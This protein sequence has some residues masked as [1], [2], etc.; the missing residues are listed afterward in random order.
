MNNEVVTISDA[1][2]M[3]PFSRKTLYKHIKQGKVSI[4][5]L[6]NGGRGIAISELV[7]V[8]GDKLKP[9][10]EVKESDK[11]LKVVTSGYDT[12]KMDLLLKKIESLENEV[13]R[14]NN[15]VENLNNRLEYKPDGNN[16]TAS[17][18]VVEKAEYSSLIDKMK[19]NLAKNNKK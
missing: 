8:Y 11:K 4:T 17:T 1:A 9:L 3:T 12:E 14:L 16:L 6:S 13:N 7:R 10:E 18:P 19:A 5:R 2:R 15:T